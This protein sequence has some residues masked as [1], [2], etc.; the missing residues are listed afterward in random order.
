MKIDW[1]DP[2]NRKPIAVGTKL[3]NFAKAGIKHMTNGRPKA[4]DEQVAERFAIC[5]GCELFEAKEEGVGRCNHES[6]GCSLKRVG[7]IGL[8][9]L[10]WADQ[11]CPLK[12]WLAIELETN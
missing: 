6:C 1:T 8:N 4:T 5:Q 3:K 10:R 11:E 7:I 12:K 2:K 9:K